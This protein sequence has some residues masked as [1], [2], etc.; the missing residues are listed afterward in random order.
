MYGDL[1]A[2]TVMGAVLAR[3]ALPAVAGNGPAV[4]VAQAALAMT[5]IAA[6][7]YLAIAVLL[8]LTGM[9]LRWWGTRTSVE[10]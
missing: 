2:P 4:Q 3:E 8:M 5:G 1:A 10:G 7:T 6:G 9:L